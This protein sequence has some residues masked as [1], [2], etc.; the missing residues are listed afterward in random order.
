MQPPATPVQSRKVETSQGQTP[1]LH[2]P[3]DSQPAQSMNL[4]F[5]HLKDVRQP[6]GLPF[7]ALG[8]APGGA[9]EDFFSALG[10]DT[11]L[12]RLRAARPAPELP[13]PGSPSLSRPAPPSLSPAG[14]TAAEAGGLPMQQSP[15]AAAGA[16]PAR[17]LGP[18]AQQQPA[19]TSARP[20]AVAEQ[21]AGEQDA[22]TPAAT[23]DRQAAGGG[24]GPATAARAPA[25]A[26]LS[27][28]GTYDGG[29]GGSASL[30][31]EPPVA[32]DT[33]TAD[34]R[35]A[36]G[37]HQPQ[38]AKTSG[39]G[40]E[41]A[42]PA[43]SNTEASSGVQ[44]THPQV[45]ARA[46]EPVAWPGPGVAAPPA[47]S[48][49]QEQGPEAAAELQLLAGASGRGLARPKPIRLQPPAAA[50][51][52]AAAEGLAEPFRVAP[53]AGSAESPHG[54]SESAAAATGLPGIVFRTSLRPPLPAA[55]PFGALGLA[56]P[57]PLNVATSPFGADSDAGFFD[58]FASGE[59]QLLFR[60]LHRFSRSL[61]QP[62][63]DCS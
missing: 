58:S 62:G 54:Q 29:N 45:P 25:A 20:P 15:S 48:L 8:S 53:A 37:D 61:Q 44:A 12:D 13:S 18:A 42:E 39:P 1:C 33:S 59:V 23:H 22:G 26:E 60:A 5:Q 17:A 14:Q 49:E 2:P 27:Q 32:A 56:P 30:A 43:A 52:T 6:T 21:D 9:D 55:L 7:G 4:P 3:A 35:P 16:Q 40:M 11:S 63:M 10:E 19:L 47:I 34:Y 41:E 36:N 28:P 24:R 50:E 46:S 31:A 51:Q 57:Q 38:Q